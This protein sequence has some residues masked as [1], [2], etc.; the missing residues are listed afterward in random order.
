MLTINFLCCRILLNYEVSENCFTTY[1]EITSHA[2]LHEG[3]LT[4]S[5][6]DILTSHI[7]LR[8]VRDVFGDAI[9]GS[10]RRIEKTSKRVFLNLKK[11][12]GLHAL[13]TEFEDELETL[14]SNISRVVNEAGDGQWRVMVSDE[15]SL[16]C[17]RLENIRCDGR[18]MVSEVRFVKNCTEE[19]IQT[20]ILYDNRAV[21][22]EVTATIEKQFCAT[23]I[24]DRAKNLLT[25]MDNSYICC[26][27]RACEVDE[28]LQLYNIKVEK[29]VL[30]HRD[31]VTEEMYFASD[32]EVFTNSGGLICSR[33]KQT[34]RSYK[35][36]EKR[37]KGKNAVDPRTNHRYMRR[38]E[39]ADKITNEKK[40]KEVE[41]TRRERIEA[42]MIE[43]EGEDDRDLREMMLSV[44]R[45]NVPED[46]VLFWE[47]QQQILETKSPKGYRWHPK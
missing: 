35:E 34:K 31:G 1:D 38:E 9:S 13:R 19:T 3:K 24:L 23:G 28:E 33:C 26:G 43:L 16:S 42:E 44:N 47:Q 17:S 40:Q 4:T 29:H 27:F 30:T 7:I 8:A 2:H 21:K 45:T 14:R 46:M 18:V 11:K 6:D 15:F 5:R 10:K 22:S 36:K 20:E 37:K 12:S 41:R 32:C 39:L 25:L